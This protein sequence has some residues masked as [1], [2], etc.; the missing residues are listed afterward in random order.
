MGYKKV[1]YAIEATDNEAFLLWEKN[2]EKMKWEQN[3]QGYM[4][5]VKQLKILGEGGKVESFPVSV[6]L[7]WWVI[8]GRTVLF[9]E[10]VSRFVDWD[11]VQEFV[12]ENLLN[13][14]FTKTDGRNAHIVF[15]AIQARN[16]REG[17]GTDKVQDTRVRE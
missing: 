2:H 6:S 4:P 13:P 12:K 3:C 8:D 5:T 9:Y 14:G 16:E 1:D 11:A 10:P 17:R 15:H 7:T